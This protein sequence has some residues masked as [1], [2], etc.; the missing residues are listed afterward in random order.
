MA[1]AGEWVLEIISL[2]ESEGVL[3]SG[4]AKIVVSMGAVEVLVFSEKID[5]YIFK[6][7]CSNCGYVESRTIKENKTKEL[8]NK[9]QET[10]CPQC[11]STSFKIIENK[12]IIEEF[13]AIAETMGTQIEILSSETEE[14]EMLYSTFGGLVA[15]LRFKIGY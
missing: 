1:L 13:G 9:I 4:P 12:S 7:E 6:I 8:E 11:D 2:S 3:I 5:L 15:I 10:R 14:G